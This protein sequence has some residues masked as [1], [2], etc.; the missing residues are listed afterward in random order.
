MRGGG[1]YSKQRRRPTK[2]QI[3]VNEQVSLEPTR[4]RRMWIP[5]VAFTGLAV[6]MYASIMYKI[7]KFGP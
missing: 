3:E 7:V 5:L 4:K 1:R 6:F 2:R